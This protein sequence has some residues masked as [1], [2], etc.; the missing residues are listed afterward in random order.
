[1]EVLFKVRD[2]G[3]TKNQNQ[4]F[5]FLFKV[6]FFLLLLFFSHC[7]W[8]G[9]VIGFYFLL[10]IFMLFFSH[11][12]Y[13]WRWCSHWC[14]SLLASVLPFPRSFTIFS[15]R[16]SRTS[17]VILMFFPHGVIVLCTLMMIFFSNTCYNFS[18]IGVPTLLALMLWLV[19][20]WCYHS[21]RANVTLV[22]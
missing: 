17:H 19:L 7:S 18:C 8:F 13:C 11:W 22:L 14:Y 21:S 6:L 1:M 2:K 15:P 4:S 9:C 10:A 5:I 20:C 3:K 12:R 16:S